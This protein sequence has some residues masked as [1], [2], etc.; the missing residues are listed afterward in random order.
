MKSKTYIIVNVDDKY[1]PYLLKLKKYIRYT[2]AEF[3][4]K[5]ERA[6][7]FDMENAV[8]TMKQAT[9]TIDPYTGKVAVERNL[10]IVNVRKLKL[11]KLNNENYIF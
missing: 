2:S 7:I 11:Q 6:E 10:K 1:F 3:T 8:K 9:R 4:N 5:F